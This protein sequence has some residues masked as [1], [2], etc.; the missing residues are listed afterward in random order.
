MYAEN[1][2]MKVCSKCGFVDPPYWLPSHWRI[3]EYCRI[4]DLKQDQP[5]IAEKLESVNPMEVVSDQYYLYRMNESGFVER[6]WIKLGKSGF[7]LSREAH[8]FNPKYR[9]PKQKTL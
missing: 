5:D 1:R 3:T 2:K 8:H 7:N 9:H 4:D 6:I